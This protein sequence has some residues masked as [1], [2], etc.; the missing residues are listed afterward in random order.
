MNALG[1]GVRYFLWKTWRIIRW[2]IWICALVYCVT[3]IYFL[4]TSPARTKEAINAIHAQRLTEEDVDGKHLPPEP[5]P[6]LVD[7]TVEGVDSNKNGIRD[8]VEL[9]IFK[10][11]PKDSKVRA[12]E[13]QYAKALQSGLD[14]VT[15]QDTLTAAVWEEDR[16]YF[17]IDETL[18]KLPKSASEAE[19][20][21]QDSKFKKFV[22][23][24]RQLVLNTV[25]RVEKRE[26]AFNKYMSSQSSPNNAFCDI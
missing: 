11:Y 8:D 26:K 4:A 7:A 14:K 16:A 15:N 1:S 20:N 2:P 6:K 24:V 3:F 17:C 23:E 21:A 13:L 19:F 12:A 9:A 22:T 10:K 25:F 18:P 5:D